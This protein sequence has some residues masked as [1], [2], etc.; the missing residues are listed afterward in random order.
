MAYLDFV[1]EYNDF[2]KMFTDRKFSLFSFMGKTE[3][4]KKYAAFTTQAYNSRFYTQNW[5]LAHI[6]PVNNESF[7]NFENKNINDILTPGEK[8]DWK[9]TPNG[10]YERFLN[11]TL[12]EEEKK[13]ARAHFLRFIH[14]INYFLV[15]NSNHV[16]IK[17]I[18]EDPAII[19][20]MR[21][22]A[23]NLYLDV[24]DDF[25]NLALSNPKLTP[26]ESC[27]ILAQQQLS[28]LEYTTEILSEKAKNVGILNKII[29]KKSVEVSS[30]TQ[31][32]KDN[33]PTENIFSEVQEFMTGSIDKGFSEK[34]LVYDNDYI[35]TVCFNHSNKWLG[36]PNESDMEKMWSI[37]YIPKKEFSK[38]NNWKQLCNHFD[39]IISEVTKGKNKG[40]YGIRIKGM[41]KNP[42]ETIIR[43]IL[44]YIFN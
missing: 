26:T 28:N 21:K 43:N 19:N 14:P 7:F 16:T 32:L 34:T 17:K 38:L 18:G 10:Y 42:N 40:C 1:P 33:L 9:L 29:I 31:N 12:S 39:I 30:P 41:K 27:N 20:Y 5:Y 35:T 6:I 36:K 22:R 44:N 25:L 15:P 13:I 2:K 8:N 11:Y 37:I 23:S 24:Y 3:V 4:E